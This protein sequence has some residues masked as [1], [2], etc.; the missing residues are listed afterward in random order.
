MLPSVASVVCGFFIMVLFF[1][2]RNSGTRIS[3]PLWIPV[4]W[5]SI[6]ASRM[7]SQWFGGVGNEA[8]SNRYIEGNSLDAVIFAGLLTAGLLVLR[9]RGPRVRAFLRANG[10]ILIF[11]L[12]CA[13][14]VLWSDYPFVTFK[15]WIKAVGDLVMILIV[16]T[17]PE[18]TGAVK[19]FLARSGFVL[20]PLSILFIKYY[21]S[22]GRQYSI[23]SGEVMYTGVATHKN[24]LGF[25]CLI[26]GLGS[27][28]S[29]FEAFRN[30]K[31][32]VGGGTLI[33]DGTVL[34]MVFWLF[35]IINS[36]TS[37]ICF[38]IG[39][40]LIIITGLRSPARKP[41]VVHFFVG[42]VLFIILYGLIINPDAGLTERVGRDSTLTGRTALW[43]EL[44]STNTNSLFGAGYESYWLGERLEKIWR[45]GKTEIGVNQAHNG[46]L[47]VFLDLGWVGVAMLGLVMAWGYRSVIHM[48]HLDPEGG[49]LRLTFFVVAVVYNLTEHAFRMLHPIWLTFL[50]SVI[51]VPDPEHQ[52]SITIR[53]P[54][55]TFVI[56]AKAFRSWI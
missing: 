27:F 43:T 44:L 54:F 9:K 53:R 3:S 40:G 30:K 12:Y 49:R 39:C 18:P 15:R 19:Q 25:I 23:W 2:N 8:A 29:L 17:D 32:A 35:T 13:A 51:V 37:L 4:I 55:F 14:S 46:Y 22:L 41:A 7:V 20:L 52:E 5:L 21:P 34:A 48:L 11:F 56:G 33:A 31:V 10:P 50:L 36:A 16:L 1:L 28:W 24:S 47:Q 38:L 26:M 45:S 6:G 42:A